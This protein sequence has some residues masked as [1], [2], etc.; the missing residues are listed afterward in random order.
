M[1]IKKLEH[2][3]VELTLTLSAATIEEDYSKTIKDYAK[4]LTLKGFRPGKA[5]VSLVES[6]YGDAIREEVTFKLMEKNLQDSYKDM[7]AKD[8]PL[9]YSTP[10][11]QNED[12]L[13]PFKPN[14]DVTYSVIYDVLPTVTLPEYK[15][16]EI[17]YP[18]RQIT[19][20][21]VN[22]EIERLREQNAMVI[23]KNGAIA[24][25][26]IVTIDYAELD[27]DGNEMAANKRDD[28]TFTVGSSY[29]FYKL[30][31]DLVGMKKGDESVIEKTYDDESGMGSDYLGKTVKI[32]V[33]VKE[34]KYKEVPE[35][36][37]DFA[38]DVKDEYKTVDDLL[39][40]TR[41]QLEDNAEEGN[42]AAKLDAVVK[43]LLEKTEI[44][45]PKS[46]VE[47]QLEQDWQNFIS[48]F[49]MSEEDVLKIMGAQGGGKENFLETRRADTIQ[50]IKGQLIIEQ[51]KE[52]QKYEVSEEEIEA[53][54]KNYGEDINKDNPNYESMKI[55]AEDDVKYK[56]ARDLLLE[57]NTF[58]P[59]EPKEESEEKKEN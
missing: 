47:A 40:A 31:K 50:N 37:D 9:P 5:P 45:V 29:N 18:A 38:Q 3:S 12:A 55:Y 2:S 46:M 23:T 21:D 28:F 53:E 8:R 56:K 36:D 32:K 16:L 58:K 24:E 48:R 25:G 6:K 26:D 10:E 1:E 13:L 49:G 27:A 51:I 39:K 52:E 34:V 14:T 41:K 20:A 7:D 22:A 44:D 35:L 42:K 17:E 11:L 43:A 59:V 15:G 4:K 19:D 33:A 57:S 54:L 30:D